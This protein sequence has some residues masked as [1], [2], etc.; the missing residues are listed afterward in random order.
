[1]GTVINCGIHEYLERERG[2]GKLFIYG[3]SIKV[4]C[5]C[6]KSMET[7]TEKGRQGV[8]PRMVRRWVSNRVVKLT[9]SWIATPGITP[10]A[11]IQNC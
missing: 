3:W 10:L 9:S 7:Y 4:H 6:R 1:M 11:V 5:K 2:A 8:H